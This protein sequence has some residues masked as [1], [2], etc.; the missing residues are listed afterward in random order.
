MTSA[1]IRKH[2]AQPKTK[3]AKR[4]LKEAAPKVI[5]NVKRQL[6]MRGSKTSPLVNE[7]LQDLV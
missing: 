4:A 6:L 3:R 5:E 1:D 7:V 2:F